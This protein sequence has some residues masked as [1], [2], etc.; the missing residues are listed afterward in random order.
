[1][2]DNQL[3]GICQGLLN[4]PLYLLGGAE[5]RDKGSPPYPIYSSYDYND[6]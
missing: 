5:E 1:M 6:D 2:G 4:A 3:A